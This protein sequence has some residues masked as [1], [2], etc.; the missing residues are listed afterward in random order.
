M[1]PEDISQRRRWARST[2][3]L[4][5]TIAVGAFGFARPVD[6][7]TGHTAEPAV[8]PT[9]PTP[10]P[11]AAANTP[12]DAPGRVHGLPPEVLAARIESLPGLLAG[13]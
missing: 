12:A 10:L 7:T 8:R 11:A 5:A 1:T 4:A 9:R 3:A 13:R 6:A 2:A